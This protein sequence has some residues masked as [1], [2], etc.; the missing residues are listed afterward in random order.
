MRRFLSLVGAAALLGTSLTLAVGSPAQ[1]TENQAH[2]NN[3]WHDAHTFG[4]SCTGY[5][6]IY[7]ST[8]CAN[9]QRANGV[10][11]NLSSRPVRLYVGCQNRS[12]NSTLVNRIDIWWA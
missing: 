10:A 12:M 7:L 3:A 11:A 2:C 1:A 9:G 4:Y 8:I 5:G 6:R